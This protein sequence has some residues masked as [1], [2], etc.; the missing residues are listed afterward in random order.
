MGRW[1]HLHSIPCLSIDTHTYTAWVCVCVLALGSAL[2]VPCSRWRARW[3][4]NTSLICAVEIMPCVCRCVQEIT[5]IAWVF[6]HS[7]IRYNRANS[8][9]VE[10]AIGKALPCPVYRFLTIFGIHFFASLNA[11]LWICLRGYEE[12]VEFA[13]YS[14]AIL[15]NTVGYAKISDRPL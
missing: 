15:G 6:A 11:A 10:P 2:C 4:A 9:I 5:T 12:K 13:W 1:L 14:W 3:R 8:L 7:H